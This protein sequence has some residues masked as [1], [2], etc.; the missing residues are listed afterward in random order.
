M[1]VCKLYEQQDIKPAM[2]Q[3]S[4]EARITALESKLGIP[5]KPKEGVVKKKEGNSQRTSMWEKKEGTLWSLPRYWL[6]NVRNPADS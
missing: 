2:E 1:K 6:E 5:S 4:A 3:T